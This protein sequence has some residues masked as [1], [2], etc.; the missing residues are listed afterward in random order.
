LSPEINLENPS[1]VDF[2]LV[3]GDQY[4]SGGVIIASSITGVSWN[5]QRG[6]LNVFNSRFDADAGNSTNRFRE[7][8]WRNVW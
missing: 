2:D 5:I 8:H 3:V 6:G 4:E 1:I 7:K